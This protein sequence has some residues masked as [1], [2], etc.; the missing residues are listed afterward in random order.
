MG[1]ASDNY[2]TA[3][4]RLQNKI[5]RWV[6]GDSRKT[7]VRKLLEK[8][9]WMSIKELTTYHTTLQLWNTIRL[10]R[11]LVMTEKITIDN[12]DKT[13]T[14]EPRLQFTRNGYR[15][16]AVESWNQLPPDLRG[17]HRLP[18]F[19]KNLRSWIKERRDKEPDQVLPDAN[20]LTTD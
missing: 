19:K 18:T 20:G 15:C 5:A 9:G 14:P 17:Q 11:P 1:G 3:A 7:R 6:T 13:Y 8:C 2:I 16:R 10:K 12:E 4:Q